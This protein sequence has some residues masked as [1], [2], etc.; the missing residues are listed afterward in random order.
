M[1]KQEALKRMEALRL[2]KEIREA[3][4]NSNKNKGPMA[5]VVELCIALSIY[6]LMEYAPRT[7][8][9]CQSKI[10][11]PLAPPIILCKI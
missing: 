1:K 4:I 5:L 9:V 11:R 2:G 6:K 3:Y 8:P 10:K 7:V